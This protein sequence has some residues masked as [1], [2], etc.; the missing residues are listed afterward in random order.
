[1]LFTGSVRF[2]VDPFETYSDEEVWRALD[3]AHIGQ[4]VRSLPNAIDATVEEGG[5]N[6]SLG[7]RQLLCMAR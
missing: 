5:R 1:M 3:R 2:N 6:F 4:H 7:E